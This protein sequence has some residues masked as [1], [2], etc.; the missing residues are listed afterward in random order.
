MKVSRSAFLAAFAYFVRDTLEYL[1][2]RTS[3]F[4][5]GVSHERSLFD[6]AKYL[7]TAWRCRVLILYIELMCTLL[8]IPM[9]D[10]H[11]QMK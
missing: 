1:I 7:L 2:K 8:N 11:N 4:V 9:Q 5:A 6:F 3:S 10:G